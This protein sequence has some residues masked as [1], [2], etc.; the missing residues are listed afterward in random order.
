MQGWLCH[1]E[2]KYVTYLETASIDKSSKDALANL[3]ATL[4]HVSITGK[5][6]DIGRETRL[7]CATPKGPTHILSFVEMPAISQTVRPCSLQEATL[8]GFEGIAAAL[9]G[10][11]S[12]V[13]GFLLLSEKSGR[14]KDREEAGSVSEIC[15][16][17][18]WVWQRVVSDS[19]NLNWIP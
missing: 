14:K 7:F 4:D 11:V 16:A 6:L 3:R 10:L 8:G 1:P 13:L 19:W 5:L 15:P 12:V 2:F 17:T 9:G 18:Y